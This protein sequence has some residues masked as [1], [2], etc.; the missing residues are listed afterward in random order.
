M[1][2]TQRVITLNDLARITNKELKKVGE[3]IHADTSLEPSKQSQWNK[4]FESWYVRAKE[5]L[6]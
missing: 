1:T 5:A 3:T 6:G 4:V 2:N